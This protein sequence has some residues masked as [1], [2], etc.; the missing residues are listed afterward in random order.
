[1]GV[2]W[3][4]YSTLITKVTNFGKKDEEEEAVFLIKKLNTKIKTKPENN[5][6]KQV[7]PPIYY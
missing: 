5:N 6:K 4:L 1:L 7:F 2:I 3:P